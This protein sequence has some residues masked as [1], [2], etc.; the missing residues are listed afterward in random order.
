MCETNTKAANHGAASCKPGACQSSHL[1]A[2]PSAAQTRPQLPR[3]THTG[4]AAPCCSAGK[5]R[6]QQALT[7]LRVPQVGARASRRASCARPLAA[8]H[9]NMCQNA[10][11]CSS[12]NAP[13]EASAPTGIATLTLLRSTSPTTIT[14]CLCAFWGCGALGDGLQ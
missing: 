8:P 2:K 9:S 10:P 13:P 3:A 5:K 14:E 6:R 4:P 1:A 7:R 11:H 12:T